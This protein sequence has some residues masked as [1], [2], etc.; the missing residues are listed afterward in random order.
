MYRFLLSQSLDIEEKMSEYTPDID[1]SLFAGRRYQEG[2][3]NLV[4]MYVKI[5][6]ELNIELGK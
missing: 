4:D 2:G 6:D 3:K 1:S 5:I